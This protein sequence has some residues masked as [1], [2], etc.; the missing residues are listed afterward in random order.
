MPYKEKE[1]SKKYFSIGDV[2]KKIN[3]KTSLIRFWENEFEI[4]NPKKNKKGLR[5]YTDKDI[6]ILQKIYS[7]VKIDGFTLDGAKKSI[8]NDNN[9]K[10]N[11]SIIDKL[12][13]IKKRL[14]SIKKEI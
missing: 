5:K 4:L 13:D 14:I 2:A 12:S 3:V 9:K 8:K 10:E 11:Q 7:L 1:I 6:S